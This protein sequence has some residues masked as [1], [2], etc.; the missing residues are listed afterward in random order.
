M[1]RA[2]PCAI[3]SAMP[4]HGST[5]Y[6]C[7]CSTRWGCSRRSTDRRP[8]PTSE[9]GSASASTIRSKQRPSACRSPSAPITANSRRRATWCRLRCVGAH[10]RRT[11]GVV[12]AA[13][14]RRGDAPSCQPHGQ[15]LHRAQPGR[16]GHHPAQHFQFITDR[17][18]FQTACP[19]RNHPCRN[20]CGRGVPCSN[21][22]RFYR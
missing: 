10:G 21:G 17:R 16:Y 14:R 8:G 11:G 5:T 4:R 15:G 1:R 19:D 20:C 2:A 13:A 9:A 6:R 22:T 12:R 18:G 3:R 7:S